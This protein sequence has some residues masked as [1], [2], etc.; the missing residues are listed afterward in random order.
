MSYSTFNQES[1]LLMESSVCSVLD[2]YGATV[3]PMEAYFFDWERLSKMFDATIKQ[4]EQWVPCLKN[5]ITPKSQT[6]KMPDD[7]QDVRSVRIHVDGI[8]KTD[9]PVLELG[10]DYSYNKFTNELFAYVTGLYVQYLGNYT[11]ESIQILTEPTF[12]VKDILSTFT[13]PAIPHPDNFKLCTNSEIYS[14]VPVV[15][16]TELQ[17]YT[18]NIGSIKIDC[19]RLKCSV[20][21]S[22]DSQDIQLDYKTRYKAIRGLDAG[23]EFFE[24]S[25][26]EKL[27][28]MQG[29]IK[30]VCNFTSM[31]NN[32]TADSLASLG[33]SIHAEVEQMRKDRNK[34]WLG[35]QALT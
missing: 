30:A 19:P 32:I 11:R 22:C 2:R 15:Y 25:L 33:Q 8:V 27:L 6:V 13:L 17:E 10:R 1:Y 35:I 12:I 28:T 23:Q 21:L 26:A 9:Q 4:F 16:N 24:A 7:C 20:K 34:F 18:C 29:N 14:L 5:Y 3:I 31:P